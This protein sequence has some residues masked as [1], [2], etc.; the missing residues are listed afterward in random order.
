MFRSG[1][2][3][4][5]LD[6]RARHHP[7]RFVVFSVVIMSISIISI[8]FVFVFVKAPAPPPVASAP[9]AAASAPTRAAKQGFQIA[10]TSVARDLR[11]GIPAARDTEDGAGR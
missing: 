5:R 4:A 10:G 9:A 8:V 7:E 3:V 1:P 6:S 2:V 11:R